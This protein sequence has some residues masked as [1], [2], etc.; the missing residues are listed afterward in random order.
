[1]VLL[2]LLKQLP[3]AIAAAP[4]PAA[5]AAADPHASSSG[6]GR[7]S[8]Y[9]QCFG[10]LGLQAARQAQATAGDGRLLA[11]IKRDLFFQC[12]PPPPLLVQLCRCC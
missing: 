9:A 6:S 12:V 5:T 7:G 11:R 3:A 1:M 4:Q 10:R 2:H 8:Q